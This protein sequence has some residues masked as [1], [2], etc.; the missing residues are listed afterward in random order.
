MANYCTGCGSEYANDTPFCSN[1][2]ARLKEDKPE[3]SVEYAPIHNSEEI[4]P[5]AA[6]PIP[7]PKQPA[8]TVQT[9]IPPPPQVPADVPQSAP[10]QNNDPATKVVSTASFWGLMLLFG[11]PIIGF[12][13]CIIMSFA[14]KNK[15][16]KHMAR[17]YLI[18]ALIGIIVFGLIAF[19]I[20]LIV[21]T[22]TDFFQNTLGGTDGILSSFGEILI[23]DAVEG[24]SEIDIS[25]YIDSGDIDIS[26]FINGEGVDISDID[27]S[28][29]EEI[30]GQ[31]D[32]DDIEAI[33]GH[34]Q[35]D[36]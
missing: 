4:Y 22:V 11:L 19:A 1:C 33:I 16:I 28:E 23:S 7:Q 2:G 5:T 3:V 24:I 17:A 12:I 32:S 13:A 35:Q 34:I 31:L 8:P 9:Q 14:P 18:W 20:S 27:V 25:Q 6:V 26:R 30:L 29:F 15:N 10:A 21:N 36:Q